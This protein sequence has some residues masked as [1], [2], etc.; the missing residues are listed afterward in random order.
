MTFD[1]SLE[2]S[3]AN[4]L[5]EWIDFNGHMNVAYYVL[6]FDKALDK[7][8]ERYDLSLDYMKRSNCSTFVLET[9]VTYLRE[10]LQGDPLLFTFQLLDADPKRLHYF[11]RMYHAEEGFLSA[12][13]E[14]LLV[15]VDM[16]ERRVVPMPLATQARL[17]ALKAVHAALPRPEQVG[18]V[19]GIRRKS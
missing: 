15:H 19:I 14:Q 7:F 10:V 2:L 5:P 17:D 9:H 11:M 8:C 3:P 16:A 12:T 1:P 13:S 18:H 4:V 6:A